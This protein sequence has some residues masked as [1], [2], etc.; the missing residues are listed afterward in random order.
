MRLL[1]ALGVLGGAT[2]IAYAFVPPACVP[3]TGE[4]EVFCLRL[5]T[6]ALF[7]MTC[8][9]LGLRRWAAAVAWPNVE[10]GFTVLAAGVAIMAFANAAEYWVFFGWPHEGPDA[11]LR[12]TLWISFLL[13]LLAVPIAA[14]VT[15][16]LL[17]RGRRRPVTVRLLGSLMVIVVSFALYVG[18]LA[19]GVLA[20]VAC[21]Y[22]LAMTRTQWGSPIESADEGT[23]GAVVE[24]AGDGAEEPA[25]AAG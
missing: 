12:G 2:W 4:S 9:F 24:D 23:G 5:W 1:L 13:G 3:V 21:L 19:V 7:A 22:G 17:I 8:G 25:A 6:P 18:L 15:G 16:V 10:R 20:L 14:T 11:W